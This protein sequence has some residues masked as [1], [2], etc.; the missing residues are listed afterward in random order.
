MSPCKAA[1]SQEKELARLGPLSE[2]RHDRELAHFV[3][4]WL[5][6]RA[7]FFLRYVIN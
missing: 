7:V 1:L 2:R 5:T 4:R 6:E 3:R